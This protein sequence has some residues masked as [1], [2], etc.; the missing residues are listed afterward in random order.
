MRLN[1]ILPA[2]GK[3]GGMQVVEKYTELLIQKGYDVKIYRGVIARKTDRFSHELTKRIHQVYC[4]FKAIIAIRHKKNY[5]CYVPLI[6]DRFIRN[7][8]VTIATSWPTSYSVNKLRDDCGE[9][10][11]FIQDYEVWDNEDA[12]INS[13]MLPLNK[14]VISEWI[15]MRMKEKPG[16]GPFPIV[17]N[18]IDN[19]V[20]NDCG[21]QNHSGVTLL[22]LNHTLEKKGVK[23]GLEVY[24]RIKEIFPNATLRMFGVCSNKNIPSDIEY[25]QNPS[26]NRIVEL[27]RETDIFIFP[28]L[29]EGWGLS[30]LEAM[31]CG[32]V[33]VGTNTGFVLDLGKHEENMM[34]SATGDVDAM[35]DNICKVINN[36]E[37]Y[38]NLQRNGIKL[39]HDLSWE[40]SCDK[41]IEI[42]S[43]G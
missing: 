25:F 18:G 23:E 37:L 2:I 1:I 22:M 24:K 9:K 13:Y 10:W 19:D 17:Y 33:V 30:P 32:C 26:R 41:L 29:E 38:Y 5:D 43:K 31:A 4:T 39:T 36:K 15:N 42:I 6:K 20:F 40:K 16:I 12:G 21:R 11:Y 7:A 34:I 14:I 27:Y 3:S 8:D 35:V 28:S